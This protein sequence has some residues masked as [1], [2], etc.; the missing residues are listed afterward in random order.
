MSINKVVITG[1]L[2]REPELKR[3]ASG[4]AILNL[5]VAV[6]DRRKDPKSGEWGD[7]ANFIDCVMFGTRAESISN[8]LHKGIKVAIDGKLRW[9][10]WER[11]GQKR[12][13]VEVTVDDIEILTPKGD[14]TNSSQVQAPIEV[15]A[16]VYDD[17]I[18]F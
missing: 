9:S 3:T 1:N 12:S 2:T 14:Q 4:M 8:Y 7:Y 18:P 10:Q 5:G 13:K 11:E 16:E 17:D 15:S 6:N